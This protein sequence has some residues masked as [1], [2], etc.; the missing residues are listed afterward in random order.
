MAKQ[1]R[2]LA[3]SFIDAMRQNFIGKG[4]DPNS[5]IVQDLYNY[6]S[7]P[8]SKAYPSTNRSGV[9][10]EQ[11]AKKM[12]EQVFQIY[13]EHI[14]DKRELLTQ[15]RALFD[16]DPVQT[17]IDVIMDDGFN[18]FIDDKDEFRI[19]YHLSEEEK[20][21]LG[22]AYEQEIQEHIDDFVERFAIK[23]RIPE[24]I[25][26]LLRDG[27][28]AYGIIG[29]DGKGI[30]DL[31]DDLDV[32]NLL[33]FYLNDKLTFVLKQED[34]DKMGTQ[35]STTRYTIAD[36][37]Y[38]KDPIVYPWHTR[39]LY[40]KAVCPKMLKIFQQGKH[41]EDLYL[42]DSENFLKICVDWIKESQ[43]DYR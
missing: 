14:A 1:W 32:I 30:T 42:E 4:A 19:E 17:I 22:D 35:M 9:L 34:R 40:E 16:T 5:I 27:E 2:G 29:E 6:E 11:S 21:I 20:D 43:N 13:K 3:K 8:R 28:Y 10:D 36:Q 25:P 26:E 37:K 23:S 15:A 39:V 18:S 7:S 12:F 24:M 31:V 33:P 41:A 38:Q